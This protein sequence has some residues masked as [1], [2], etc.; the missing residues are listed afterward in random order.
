M[1]Q[2]TQYPLVYPNALPRTGGFYRDGIVP[3][4][5]GEQVFV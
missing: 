3:D 4:L 1:G 2:A 5:T